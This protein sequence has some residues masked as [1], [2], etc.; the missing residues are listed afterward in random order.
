VAGP[1]KLADHIRRGLITA[2]ERGERVQLVGED[3]TVAP[4]ISLIMTPGHTPGHLCLV[5]SSAGQRAL[6]PGDAI[7]CPVQLDEPSWQSMAD[8]DPELAQRVRASLFRK[9]EDEATTGVGAHF[10]ELAFGR[11]LTGKGRRWHI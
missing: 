2:R 6:L 8:V 9:L 11:V 3:T 10:P 4:G 5:V 1:A 7:T